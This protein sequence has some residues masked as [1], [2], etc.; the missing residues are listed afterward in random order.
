M[1]PGR[2]DRNHAIHV[3]VQKHLRVLVD[4]VWPVAMTGDEV[5]VT[6]LQEIVLNPAEDCGGVALA[7]FGDD[8]A[9]RETAAGAKR[10]RQEIWSAD[11][12]A[13]RRHNPFLGF[14]RN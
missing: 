12:V 6:F 13:C 9:Y 2:V 1:M 11:E 5:E 7:D 8:D 4:Q 10:G 3:A 14:L